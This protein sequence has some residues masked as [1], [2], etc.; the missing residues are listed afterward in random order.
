MTAPKDGSEFEALGRTE[1]HHEILLG[2]KARWVELHQCFADRRGYEIYL[3]GW[4]PLKRA[5]RI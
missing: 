2:F 3:Q 4:K 5:P 1:L